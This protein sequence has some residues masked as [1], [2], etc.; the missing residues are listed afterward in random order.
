MAKTYQEI[1]E[2]IR[3]KQA[4]V[5]TAEEMI[6]IVREKGVKKAAED[7]DVVTTGTFGPMCSSGAFLNTGHT[8]PKMKISRAWLND[9][10]A[11]CGLAAV[12]LYIGATEVARDDP[13]NKAF[14]GKFKYGGGHV[15][16]ELVRG[17]DIVFEAEGYG[18]DCYPRR[19]IKTL[20]NI[21]DLNNAFIVN[22]RNCYQNY[23]VAVN[24]KK[25]KTI[26]TYMG[27]LRPDI[28]NAGYCSAGQLSPLLNDPHYRTIGIGTRIFLGGGVGY[29]FR[30][31][32]QHAPNS[33]RDE[34][35][36]P[37]EG[38]GTIAVTGDMK[39]MSAEFIR[40]VSM[41]GYGVSLAMG[42]GIPIPIL[43]E[44]MAKFTS[45]SDDEIY[46]PVMDYSLDYPNFTG[47]PLDWV[48]YG[49]LRKGR[50]TL[51]GH[52]VETFSISSYYKARQIAEIL[53][54]W[55][56]EGEFLLGKPVETLPGEGSEIKCGKLK[57]RPV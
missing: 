12:D 4:V 25:K 37:R 8:V 21:K 22:P 19:E 33:P 7:V 26:Y 41:T 3:K 11:Y 15:I 35:G 49:D 55:I 48:S 47:K 28:A 23:N 39:Q 45:V 43:D 53:K 40:G 16:E 42:I 46:A 57:Y 5:V 30:H 56:T 2:K 24:K 31:G 20:I 38:A 29:V 27:I 36:I 9:V 34:N 10:F 14:P 13:L 1:N 32:T 51:E 18:T 54:S 17:K 52:E 50:I 6:N 44:E